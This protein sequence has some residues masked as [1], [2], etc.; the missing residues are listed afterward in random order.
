VTDAAS[1]HTRATDGFTR[2]ILD[3]ATEAILHV[4]G[5]GLI[6]GV[7][8]AAERMFGLAQDDVRGR[9]VDVLMPGATG[10]RHSDNVEPVPAAG[11]TSHG[12]VGLRRDGRRFPMDF[13]VTPFSFDG[14]VHYTWIVRDVTERVRLEEQLHQSQK[15]EALGQLAGGVA[16]DVNNL[17]TV[18]NGWCETLSSALSAA[19]PSGMALDAVAH[20]GG[21]AAQAAKLTG[22][23]L[24]FTRKTVVAPVVV[25]LN[26]VIA[27]VDRMLRRVLGEDV[28]LEE[29]F[30]SAA[31]VRVDPGQMGQV[32]VNLAINAR[33]AMPRGGRLR[34]ATQLVT[35]DAATASARQVR[36]GRYV[37][38]A[39]SDTGCG[40]PADVRTRVFEPFFTTKAPGRGTGLGLATVYGIV[41]QSDGAIDV[42]SEPG[43]GTTFTVLLPEVA[44][45]A[46]Q[47]VETPAGAARQDS[48]SETILVLEDDPQV[49]RII[50]SML[51]T[52]GYRVLAAA[53]QRQALAAADAEPHI[54]MLL[55]DVVLPEMSGPEVAE[56]L[57]TTHPDASVLF[58]S[59]Y[60]AD[61]V[62]RRGV[63][64]TGASFLQKPF[65]GRQLGRSVRE[66]LDRRLAGEWT[67]AAAGSG[68]MSH[69]LPGERG[70]TA[71]DVVRP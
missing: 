20:I 33:D 62:A 67:N 39:V 70:G 57:R 54:D 22:Q 23:L 37:Q 8:L 36:P 58:V 29:D 65:T 53:D 44:G 63:P 66:V 12:M 25:D 38:L 19:A 31:Q 5:A 69:P 61:A 59:G 21:A 2:S 40:M 7:N 3:H 46:T 28:T 1:D 43:R 34:I 16:H 35:L 45:H 9:R 15:M 71:A 13:S 49:R 27:Y 60:T 48:G 51:E 30:T 55:S 56:R 64:E 10:R 50:V 18:I 68:V 32:L 24:A 6:Q 41:R 47:A 17:L 11:P 4:D 26:T 14:E 52:R 42:E